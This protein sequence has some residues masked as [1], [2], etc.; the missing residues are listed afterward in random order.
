MKKERKFSSAIFDYDEANV[1]LQFIALKNEPFL[2]FKKLKEI[3]SEVETFDLEEERNLLENIRMHDIGLIRIKGNLDEIFYRTLKILNDKKLPVT[4]AN[5][6]LV[7][8]YCLGICNEKTGII[9]FDA[10]ADCKEEYENQTF[11]R[12][13]WV[14]RFC[15]LGNSKQL[16]LIGLRSLDEEEFNF[17]K[18]NQIKFL[19]ANEIKKNLEK[20]VMKF[21]NFLNE[22][23][24]FY[25]SFDCDVLDPSILPGVNYP[26]PEGL[27][28]EEIF[29]FFDALKGKK[30]I[31]IDFVEFKHISGEIISE[32]VITRILY[33]LLS[34]IK[35]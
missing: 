10:H 7:T 16:F 12:G 35:L 1:V 25:I 22:F 29:S 27:S 28:L 18:E 32:K 4:F 9:I 2:H 15:E 8:L 11:S 21:K 26:E 24:Q 13:T 23:E 19:K 33:K 30:V 5:N 31:G 14:K 20:S 34:K 3:S 17:L 6:H